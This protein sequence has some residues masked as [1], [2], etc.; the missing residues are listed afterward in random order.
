M[1]T[2]DAIKY[3]A[4]AFFQVVSERNKMPETSQPP[5]LVKISPDLS[6]QDKLDIA[7]VLSNKEVGDFHYCIKL[8]LFVFI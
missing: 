8:F 5:L 7:A 6:N 1:F 2:V 3:D 4:M